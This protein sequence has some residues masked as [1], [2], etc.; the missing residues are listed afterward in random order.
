MTIYKVYFTN[1]GQ[2]SSPHLRLLADF[3]PACRCLN[4]AMA[5]FDGTQ[6]PRAKTGTGAGKS[7]HLAYPPRS[8]DMRLTSS[9]PRL[10]G[11]VLRQIFYLS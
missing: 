2:L 11:E 4:S 8:F 10:G 6:P 5:A 7:S 1:N 9:S 3:A